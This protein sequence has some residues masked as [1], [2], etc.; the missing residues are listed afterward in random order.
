MT[1][2]LLSAALDSWAKEHV[3]WYLVHKLDLT[4]AHSVDLH[5]DGQWDLMS[6]RQLITWQLMTLSHFEHT[7]SNFVNGELKST[8][9]FP[10]ET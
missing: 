1:G 4:G 2:E 5:G 6:P 8:K 10:P 3:S 7:S 9:V